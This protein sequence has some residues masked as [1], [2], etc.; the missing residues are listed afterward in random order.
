MVQILNTRGKL[1]Q[2]GV[3]R[4]KKADSNK[5]TIYPLLKRR[6]SCGGHQR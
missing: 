6:Y 2:R 1:F 5:D 4:V 3:W